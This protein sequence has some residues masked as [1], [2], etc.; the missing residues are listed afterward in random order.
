MTQTALSRQMKINEDL[1]VTYLN[2]LRNRLNR[3]FYEFI[4]FQ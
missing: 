1:W 2:F 3:T 4:N